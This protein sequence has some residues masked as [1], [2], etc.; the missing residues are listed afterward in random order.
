MDAQLGTNL[1]NFLV[2]DRY[3]LNEL[4]RLARSV[5]CPAVT[6]IVRPAHR[7]IT[8]M[9]YGVQTL[10]VLCSRLVHGPV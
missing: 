2:H 6:F 3:D 9:H 5:N 7:H 10:S 4:Q 8:S 1:D